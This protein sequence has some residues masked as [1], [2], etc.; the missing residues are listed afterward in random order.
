MQKT[1]AIKT[2]AVSLYRKIKASNNNLKFKEN[3]SYN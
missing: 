3:E 2:I 1:C